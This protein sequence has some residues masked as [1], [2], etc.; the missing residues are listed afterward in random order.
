[1]PAYTGLEWT[2]DT[3]AAIQCTTPLICS[4][5]ESYKMKK[6]SFFEDCF[7]IMRF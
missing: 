4:W 2:F 1:M 5:R 3:A 6:Q 7:C